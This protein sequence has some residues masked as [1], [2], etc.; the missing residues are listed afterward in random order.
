[1]D[2]L[3]KRFPLSRELL[4]IKGT[5]WIAEAQPVQPSD[6]ADIKFTSRNIIV[7][8]GRSPS[9]VIRDFLGPDI[10]AGFRISK[11]ALRR[12]LVVSAELAAVLY[13]E[14]GLFPEICNRLKITSYQTLKGVWGGRHYPIVWYEEDWEAIGK[15]F[16]FDEHIT[17]E[18]AAS[19]KDGL[20]EDS[21]LATIEKV[22]SDLGRNEQIDSLTAAIARANSQPQKR[23]IEI[24]IPKDRYAEIHCV[25]VCFSQDGKLLAAKRPATKR[26]YPNCLEFGCG[27]LSLGETFS[28]CL[29]RAYKDDFG[30]DLILPD[31]PVPINI[32][33]IRDEQERRVIPGIIF[34]AEIANVDEVA[35]K[36]SRL[37][38]SEI[39]WLDPVSFRADQHQCVPNFEATIQKAFEIRRQREQS[40]ANCEI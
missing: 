32:Y 34:F 1:M 10:D 16:L 30:V 11:F 24:E 19:V 21:T 38:H 12:R 17:S 2:I 27:Q 7:E 25:A 31:S 20:R 28:D 39:M 18:I 26:R 13:R 36:F 37:K 14:R 9:E 15:T 4:A 33:E 23:K 40:K 5:V 29:K 3:H 35:Q 8:T 22:F 6:A